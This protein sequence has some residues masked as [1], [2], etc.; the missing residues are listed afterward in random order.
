MESTSSAKPMSSIRSTSSSTTWFNCDRSRL[1]RSRRSLMRP[2]VPTKTSTPARR[3]RSASMQ[4]MSHLATVI[5]DELII[6]IIIIIVTINIFT[7]TNNQF[8][9]GWPLFFSNDFPRVF[10]N[11]K[12]EF[13]WPIGTAYFFEI[14]D[15]RFMNAYQNKNISSCS[16]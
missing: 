5:S 3:L 16:S 11:Q 4:Q 8:K 7:N 1:P 12:N 15:T 6:S 14:H 2:G 10:H 13:S 9:A